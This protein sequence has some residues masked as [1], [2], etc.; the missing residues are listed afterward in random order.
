MNE[1]LN[2]RHLRFFMV[3]A[4]EL[5]FR[6]AAERLEMT[7]GPLSLAIQALEEDLG[8]RLFQRTRRSVELT[9]AGKALQA[10]T[11]AIFE[12]VENARTHVRRTV[13][14]EVG[15]LTLGFTSATSL[16]PFFPAVI[17]QYR[18]QRPN[19]AVTL[20]ELP[21]TLQMQALISGEIDAGMLR[22]RGDAPAEVALTHLLDEPLLVAMQRSHRLAR[23]P[24]IRIEELRD[25]AFIAYPG[26]SGV[27]LHE[28]INQLCARRG[29][30]PRVVQEACEPSTIIG[31]AAAGLGIA[32]VPLGLRNF[33]LPEVV[34]KRIADEDAVSALY[35]AHR[36]GNASP[37]VHQFRQLVMQ[38]C[39][40][41][42]G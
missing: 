28:T 34:F 9:E 3:L 16:M 41:G 1:S 17:Q 40:P 33:S 39:T 29:F 37:T 15:R 5:H 18:T 42:P 4:Q 22:L 13:A 12:R 26:A 21:S 20:R 7:Q 14:G 32:I 25:E 30:M 8:A 38:T 19:V 31:L 23:E 6:R 36:Y 10:T 35:F 2:L 11:P 27:V 24:S